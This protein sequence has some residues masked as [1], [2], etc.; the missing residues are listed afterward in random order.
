[1]RIFDLRANPEKF[2]QYATVLKNRK[3]YEKTLT[4]QRLSAQEKSS[5]SEE[6]YPMPEADLVVSI[7]E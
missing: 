4:G 5:L 1:M 6:L 2:E 7:E 3:M